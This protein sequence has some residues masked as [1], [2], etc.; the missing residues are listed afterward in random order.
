MRLISCTL[1]QQISRTVFLTLA[2]SL[3]I[4][5]SW[6]TW[7]N[8][9]IRGGDRTPSSQEAPG[10]R[11]AV[12][13]SLVEK[14]RTAKKK[15]KAEKDEVE[16]SFAFEKPVEADIGEG[17]SENRDC[18]HEKITYESK[19]CTQPGSCSA[20]LFVL[21][22]DDQGRLYHPQQMEHLFEFLQNTMSPHTC[23]P[24]EQEPCFDDVS[25]VVAAHGWRHNADFEDW[26]LRQLR[27]V[28]YSAVLF[29]AHK[30]SKGERWNPSN[31]PRKV[32][33]VYLGWRGAL[34]KEYPNSPR[35]PFTSWT[36][37]DLTLGLPAVLSFWDRKGAALDVALGSTRELFAR[38]G[39][40]RANVNDM[41]D[42]AS[43]TKR[44]GRD[45]KAYDECAAQA[46]SSKGRCVAMRTLILGHS[47]GSLAIYN[48]ISESLIDSVSAGIESP[49]ESPT[50]QKQCPTGEPSLGEVVSS[51]YADL[52]VLIN[53]AFEGARFEPLYQASLNRMKRRPYI[54]NQ[55]PVLVLVT[56]TS[57]YA[58]RYAF[59]IGRFFSTLFQDNSPE[60]K[61]GSDIEK[62]ADEERNANR[63][64]VGHIPRYMTHYLDSF[65]TFSDSESKKDTD[66]SL[67]IC[68]KTG[69]EKLASTG[70]SGEKP[71]AAAL[72][73]EAVEWKRKLQES[74]ETKT[75]WPA[76][77]FCGGLRL[78]VAMKEAREGED[79]LDD[80]FDDQSIDHD[81]W[82][83]QLV[84]K[85]ILQDKWGQS[86]R[87]PHNPIWVVRTKDKNIIDGHNG[88][89]NPRMEGFI[90]Q[91]YREALN[92]Q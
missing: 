58:T 56:G 28:L 48:A 6:F 7:T 10:D 20:D 43:K 53:P 42:S 90:Q 35:I 44:M 79:P 92:P 13:V 32:V 40:I 77:A 57:D 9:S 65:P 23:N 4:G 31:R 26:N 27:E 50:A 76:R 54:C 89:H 19:F 11:D 3:T 37:S 46:K 67:D 85:E 38:L 15:D 60:S 55:D 91:L 69:W 51:P 59:P 62:R 5:C 86:L 29:E 72:D 18:S 17:C 39:H 52:I 82:S 1:W 30:S 73:E 78:S 2:V 8:S 14:D 88:F 63:K 47:F 33:G 66:T 61:D 45:W 83:N 87:S 12:L 70:F 64:T 49:K 34:V 16:L 80:L 21:E 71:L 25:L 75:N 81:P 36:L 24:G 74:K 22:F 84:T 68:L 41:N